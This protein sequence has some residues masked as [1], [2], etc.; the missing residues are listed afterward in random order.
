VKAGDWR[1]RGTKG[2]KGWREGEGKERGHGEG[3]K[4][5]K[6]IHFRIFACA[7]SAHW[8]SSLV[9][10]VICNERAL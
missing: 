1:K 10:I 7:R 6:P 8:R 3:R 5:N 2:R 4:R 9:S